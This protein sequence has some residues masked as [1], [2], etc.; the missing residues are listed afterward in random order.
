MTSLAAVADRKRMIVIESLGE[1]MSSAYATLKSM[2][3]NATEPSEKRR[4]TNKAVAV[5]TDMNRWD[6][7][8]RMA[9][10]DPSI[11]L[12]DQFVKD[13]TYTMTSPIAPASMAQGHSLVLDYARV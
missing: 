2:A 10:D 3:D 5:L 9:A 13:V 7:L 8:T 1:R 4:L 12:L 11:D 6:E